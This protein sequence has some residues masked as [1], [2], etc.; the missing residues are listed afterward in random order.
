[1]DK[2]AT[3]HAG[4]A[5]ARLAA[6]VGAVLHGK[7]MLLATAES[8][9]GGGAAQAVTEIAGSS[10]WFSAASSPTRTKRRANYWA[11]RPS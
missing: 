10:G 5:L 2:D 6:E 8:C 9:T 4:Q 3:E 1:M 11:C 7:G